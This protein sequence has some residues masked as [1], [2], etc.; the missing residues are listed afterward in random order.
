MPELSRRFDGLS[1]HRG[2]HQILYTPRRNG[3]SIYASHAIKKTIRSGARFDKERSARITLRTDRLRTMHV[4]ESY[5]KVISST[6]QLSSPINFF[7]RSSTSVHTRVVSLGKSI[8]CPL[9]FSKI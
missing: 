1:S 6:R 5:W 4:C 9:P 3:G 7:K 2:T 8:R